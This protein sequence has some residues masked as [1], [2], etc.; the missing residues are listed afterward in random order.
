M[1][2]NLSVVI[3]CV[4]L[5]VSAH[6]DELV[7]V[8][9]SA[10][11]A[12]S[13]IRDADGLHE[14]TDN[15]SFVYIESNGAYGYT[16]IYG[17][18]HDFSINAGQ[19]K[20][21]VGGWTTVDSVKCTGPLYLQRSEG[22]KYFYM[23]VK[24]DDG[25]PVTVRFT[26]EFDSDY[27]NPSENY[28]NA[29]I[30]NIL[31]NRKVLDKKLYD[32]LIATQDVVMYPGIIYEAGFWMRSTNFDYGQHAHTWFRMFAELSSNTLPECLQDSDCG[33]NSILNRCHNNACQT[34]TQVWT[35]LGSG[36]PEACGAWET[37]IY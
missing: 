9:E 37:D 19:K 34:C 31:T 18:P 20:F 15:Y 7:I 2:K 16:S 4:F 27:S 12:T 30:V 25:G 17:D 6:A 35:D 36:E 1:L 11:R 5:T 29:S 28:V 13:E 3:F 23:H 8:R 22:L 14:T 26:L 33:D 32:S 24:S 21:L 10:K